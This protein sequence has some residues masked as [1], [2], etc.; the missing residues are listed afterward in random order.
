MT[1]MD[2]IKIKNR[3]GGPRCDGEKETRLNE[4]PLIEKKNVLP[5]LSERA[6]ELMAKHAIEIQKARAKR[7]LA[8]E[9]NPDKIARGNLLR[10]P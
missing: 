3:Y 1:I 4:I 5:P 10:S 9:V 7:R 2:E 6:L 8:F